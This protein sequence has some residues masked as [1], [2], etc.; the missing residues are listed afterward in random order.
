MPSHLRICFDR[1]KTGMVLRRKRTSDFLSYVSEMDDVIGLPSAGASLGRR[2]KKK[3]KLKGNWHEGFTLHLCTFIFQECFALVKIAWGEHT[4]I[5]LGL[6][7]SILGRKWSQRERQKSPRFRYEVWE[8]GE[9]RQDFPPPPSSFWSPDLASLDE[10]GL[11][12]S[13]GPLSFMKWAEL[14]AKVL[15]WDNAYSF[16]F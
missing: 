12:A 7:N 5:E 4:F 14:W 1:L 15:M 11:P 8:N 10:W 2:K 9:E 6:V 13:V 16:G 3:G